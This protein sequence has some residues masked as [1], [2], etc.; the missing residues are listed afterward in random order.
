MKP[1]PLFVSLQMSR[2]LSANAASRTTH[3]ITTALGTRLVGLSLPVPLPPSSLSPFS[4]L[5]PPS[6]LLLR[7]HILTNEPVPSGCTMVTV[8]HNCEV[9]LVL[10]GMVDAEKEI[11]KLTER[12]AK[13][14]L[15]LEK[16]E[17]MRK[18]ENY[19]EKVQ[20]C[21]CVYSSLFQL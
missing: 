17:S 11:E 15:Q 16:L 3:Q 5:S 10:R 12:V 1:L 9:H 21:V 18:V 8:G 20:L 4:F 7:L 14:N 13:I 2:P 6:S 19:E